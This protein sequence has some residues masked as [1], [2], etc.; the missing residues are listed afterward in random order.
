[1]PYQVLALIG[2]LVPLTPAMH[3]LFTH[4]FDVGQ[5]IHLATASAASW[6]AWLDVIISA[7]TVL[8]LVYFEGH[9]L[10][11]KRLWLFCIATVFVGPSFGLPLF[12]FRR[13]QWKQLASQSTSALVRN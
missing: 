13:W 6:T 1:M 11:M 9:R 10:G 8:V 3:F 2:M 12:L 7:V 4:Q 5:F